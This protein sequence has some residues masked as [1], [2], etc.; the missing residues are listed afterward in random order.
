M[1]FIPISEPVLGEEERK[2]ILDC[3]DSGWISSLGKY[4]PLFEENFAKYCS[5]KYG[6][7]V[8]NGTVAIQLALKALNIGK[9]DEVI[10]PNLTFVATANAVSYTGARPIFVDS[11][12]KTWNIDPE[13]IEA[14]ITNQTKAIIVVHLYGH[15]CDIDPILEIAKKHNIPIIEDA[16]EAHGAEYK[17]KKTGSFGLISC[18]SFYANKTITTGEG[19]ICITDDKNLFDRMNFLKDHGMSKEKRYWHPEIGFNFRMT[20]LQAAIGVAQLEKIEK[21]IQIKRKNALLYN[22]LLKDIKGITLP[23]EKEWAKSTYW[24]YSI[25][26]DKD[27]FGMNRDELILKLKENKIDSRP[28]FYPMNI[29]P[30]YKTEGNFSTS[31]LIASQGINLPSSIKL[32]EKQIKYICQTIKTIYD[33]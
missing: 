5:K 4:I 17:G 29:L 18:F 22:L 14:A 19:G 25:L 23:P 24:M 21:F 16:A 12:N 27:K 28:F 26:I 9:G 2:N 10:I 13:K 6:V 1:N 11:E 30:P 8:S 7:A 33:S 32:T 31:E 3:V 20:N 15:P